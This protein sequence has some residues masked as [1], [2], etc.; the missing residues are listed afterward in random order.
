MAIELDDVSSGYSTG[1]INTNFQRTE[2]ELNNNVLRRDGLSV[3]EANQMEV[4]LDMNTHKIIN[5][6][7]P[8]SSTDAA[9]LQDV[10]NAVSGATTANLIS[11]TPYDFITSDSVQ[12]AVEE[13]A[14]EVNL[15]TLHV[16][17]LSNL[18]A[19]DTSALLD[20]RAII[21]TTTQRAGIFVWDASNLSSKVTND[22]GEVIYVAPNSDATGAS[23]AFIRQFEG[24]L[25]VDWAGAFN[26][27]TNPTATL[28]AINN[29]I[30]LAQN[31][32]Y[33]IIEFSEGTYQ[34]NG[35]IT[36][37][38]SLLC[39]IFKG[40]GN[41]K[42]TISSP[43]DDGLPVFYIEGVAGTGEFCGGY[44]QDLQ[45]DGFY[46]KDA[47]E[48]VGQIGFRAVNVQFEKCRTAW[49]VHNKRVGDFTEY[50][51]AENCEFGFGC[52]NAI[53]Y[54]V[55]SG[56]A[57]FHG[58][59]LWRCQINE[60][61]TNTLSPVIMDTGAHVYNSPLDFQVW[62]YN[63]NPII[64]VVSALDYNNTYG[65]IT[66]EDFTG[67]GFYEAAALSGSPLY[68]AGN[69]ISFRPRV[70]VGNLILCERIQVNDDNTVTA[71]KKKK[72]IAFTTTANDTAVDIG[73]SQEDTAKLVYASF[74]ATG[75]YQY[76]LLLVI[77]R[78]PNTYF[79]TASTLATLNSA[80]TPGWG[81]P[82]FSVASDGT[83]TISN[84]NYGANSVFVKLHISDLGGGYD[85]MFDLI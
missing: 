22:P 47:I 36:K 17:T 82:T 41:N 76:E 75:D 33:G 14:D 77:N 73:L 35:T 20:N 63:D 43:I 71:N 68:H 11:F 78:S 39:P 26:D 45:I 32:G 84:P 2:D 51:V 38:S 27:N 72:H 46:N 74:I 10:Q 13:L 34:V 61:D 40:A 16:D 64:N 67:S 4:E 29:T 15:A 80:N 85:Q 8:T 70:K 59:G 12:G 24:S 60:L 65:T 69:L 23:G 54:L 48:I 58:S 1:T 3:G 5:L 57:S 28:A 81:A 62:K 49:F 18:K 79:G 31:E 55:T 19:L 52:G 25:K 83:L 7:E 50:C 30:L 42:T 6:A 56:N 53:R 21:V 44:I 66:V 37:S 9:R